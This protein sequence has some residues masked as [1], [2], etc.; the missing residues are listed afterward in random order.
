MLKSVDLAQMLLEEATL[1]FPEALA[2]LVALVVAV[3]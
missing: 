1:A 2:T 3:A